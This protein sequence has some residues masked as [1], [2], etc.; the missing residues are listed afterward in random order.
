V[1]TSSAARPDDLLASPARRD[2]PPSLAELQHEGG[3]D[4]LS[5]CTRFAEAVR[6]DPELR[7]GRAQ[8]GV[9]L[10]GPIDHRIRV[11][12]PRGTG[13]RELVCFDS[14]SYLGLHLHPR[15]V[16]AAQRALA[17]DGA[18][19]P[20]AQL[21]AGTTRGLRR[22]EERVAAF[23]GRAAAL[24]FPSGYAANLGTLTALLGSGDVVA[25]DQY[26]HASVHDG[27]RWSGATGGGVYRHLD[28][29]HLGRVLG[30]APVLRAGGTLVATDGVFSMHGHVAPLPALRAAADEHGARLLVDEAHSVGVLGATGRG[31]EELFGLPGRIDLLVGTFSKAPGGVGGYVCASADV[32]EY[33]RFF[34]RASVFTASMPPATIAAADEAFRVMAE[35]PEHREALWENARRLHGAL[36]GVG[37]AMSPL[38]SPIL[39]VAVGDDRRLF[40]LGQALFEAGIKVGT[41][42]HPAV[43]RGKSLLRLSVNAR[44]RAGDLDRTAEVLGAL[45]R[46]FGL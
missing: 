24:I 37:I 40:A 41:V 21:L 22:L 9:E 2:P 16:A 18:G 30:R 10:L 34:A 17:E 42:S 33:L 32:I 3:A 38:C 39:T 4:L 43:P 46:R 35:E 31:L 6:A 25:R 44:H 20:S 15:V 23:H 11:R 45:A 12:D 5:K 19:V 26:A 1:Y 27:V 36:V 14:N 28:M 8:Y 13:V 29:A 7:R